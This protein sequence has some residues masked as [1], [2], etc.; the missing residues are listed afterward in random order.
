M[1]CFRKNDLR[2]DWV[3]VV[4]RVIDQTPCSETV[5]RAKIEKDDGT[6]LYKESNEI[7]FDINDIGDFSAPVLDS[8]LTRDGNVVEISWNHFDCVDS[9]TIEIIDKDSEVSVHTAEVDAEEI[10]GQF[11][12]KYDQL[13]EC[14][15]Y[16][17][18]ISFVPKGTNAIEIR[19]DLARWIIDADVY[20]DE[21]AEGQSLNLR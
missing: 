19:S 9:Y 16:Q 13:D 11:T 10:W 12:F 18:V 6:I 20:A 15:S 7:M 21:L 8:K 5:Y 1:S 4:G 2:E 17:F 14:K 3:S